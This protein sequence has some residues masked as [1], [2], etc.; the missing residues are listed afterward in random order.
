MNKMR[1][2]PLSFLIGGS[3]M[4]DPDQALSQNEHGMKMKRYNSWKLDQY[5]KLA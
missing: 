4:F 5:S 2:T 1:I 3:L